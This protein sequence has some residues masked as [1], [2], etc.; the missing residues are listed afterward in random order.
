MLGSKMLMPSQVRGGTN[1]TRSVLL[2][3]ISV[4]TST[5]CHSCGMA[6]SRLIAIPKLV[7]RERNGLYRTVP[8]LRSVAAY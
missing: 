6:A 5:P 4:P 3:P 2:R 1:D 8:W 7:S